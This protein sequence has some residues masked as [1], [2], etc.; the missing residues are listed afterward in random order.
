MKYISKQVYHALYL[1]ADIKELTDI[2]ICALE[3]TNDISYFMWFMCLWIYS[4]WRDTWL[5]HD[6]H[7][8]ESSSYF[9]YNSFEVP[10]KTQNKS[11]W[12]PLEWPLIQQMALM[13]VTTVHTN[14]KAC[15]YC[16]HY[17]GFFLSTGS[18]T[19]HEILVIWY[20]GHD[21]KRVKA[22]FIHCCT[23]EQAC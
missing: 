2:I 1:Y 6:C 18:L 5:S 11:T 15:V 22:W 4:K 20:M 10:I 14:L 21:S 16:W 7:M 3:M 8:I 19:I 23:A 13:R 12:V 9:V 17:K